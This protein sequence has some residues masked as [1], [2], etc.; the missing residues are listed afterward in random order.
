VMLIGV[1]CSLSLPWRHWSRST[2]RAAQA[3]VQCSHPL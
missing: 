3:C 1:A 2:R